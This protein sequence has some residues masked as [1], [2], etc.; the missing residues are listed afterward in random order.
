MSVR[1]GF[2]GEKEKNMNQISRG[3]NVNN[4]VLARVA[5]ENEFALCLIL[6]VEVIF[7]NVL[8]CRWR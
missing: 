1:H 5:Y 7:K 3:I 4:I 2:G 8:T 6:T